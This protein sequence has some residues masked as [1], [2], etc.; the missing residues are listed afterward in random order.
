M[1][2]HLGVVGII[3]VLLLLEDF[4]KPG[5]ILPVDGDECGVVPGFAAPEKSI[6]RVAF[7]SRVPAEP[8]FRTFLSDGRPQQAERYG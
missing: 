8:Q 7:M 5:I 2:G 6:N 4:R 1:L 3:P